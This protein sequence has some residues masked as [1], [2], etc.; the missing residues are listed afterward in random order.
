MLLQTYYKFHFTI[1]G[2][3]LAHKSHIIPKGPI[4]EDEQISPI[5]T[6]PVQTN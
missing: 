2:K 6:R 1:T 3:K 4:N 5:I